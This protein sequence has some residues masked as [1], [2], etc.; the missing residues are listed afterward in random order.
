[1][2]KEQNGMIVYK[3]SVLCH[4]IHPRGVWKDVGMDLC[5]SGG[6]R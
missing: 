4:D 2:V 6:E 3:N 5:W 1:M